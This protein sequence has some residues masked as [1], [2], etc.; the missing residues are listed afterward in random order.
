MKDEDDIIDLAKEQ[1]R[2]LKGETEFRYGYKIVVILSSLAAQGRVVSIMICSSTSLS[3]KN[4]NGGCSLCTC[5]LA[6]Q[7]KGNL[8]S[9]LAT[10]NVLEV[11]ISRMH[12]YSS[13]KMF[14]PL[15][16]ALGFCQILIHLF[17]K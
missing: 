3:F 13:R 15:H 14:K 9:A 8:R 10:S 5:R 6:E 1:F 4:Q 7:E 17:S 12:F 16:F 2:V 11:C